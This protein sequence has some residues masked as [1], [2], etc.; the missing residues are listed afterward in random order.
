MKRC[1]WSNIVSL[2]K[3]SEEYGESYK[4]AKKHVAL[5]QSDWH[6]WHNC[7]QSDYGMEK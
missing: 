4:Y 6:D 1:E 5:A 7:L 3:C 2:R